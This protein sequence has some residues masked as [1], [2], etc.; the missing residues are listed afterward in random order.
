VDA[1]AALR[2]AVGKELAETKWLSAR[3]ADGEA[4][5]FM[6][7]ALANVA[8]VEILATSNVHLAVAGTSAARAG[9]RS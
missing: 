7:L 6:A 3:H 4:L 9:P 1:L 8:G 5:A 2:G